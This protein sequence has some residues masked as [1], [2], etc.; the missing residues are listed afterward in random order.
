MCVCVFVTLVIQHAMRMRHIVMWSVPLCNIFQQCL[1][2]GTILGGGGGEEGEGEV[3]GGGEK[4]EG[5]EDK[6]GG[7]EGEEEAEEE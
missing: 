1:I 3:G 5:D 4:G 6:G 2:N 7:W